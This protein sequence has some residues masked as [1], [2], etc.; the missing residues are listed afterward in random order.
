MGTGGRDAAPISTARLADVKVR[1]LA[2]LAEGDAITTLSFVPE[3]PVETAGAPLVLDEF[4]LYAT[5]EGLLSDVRALFA[6]I[7]AGVFYQ[8]LVPGAIARLCL[9]TMIGAFFLPARC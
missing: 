3:E 6:S 1:A 2:P 5:R 9:L 7:P 4:G 8:T